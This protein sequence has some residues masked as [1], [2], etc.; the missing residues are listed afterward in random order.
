M[1]RCPHCGRDSG[2]RES[3]NTKDSVTNTLA[4]AAKVSVT[5]EGGGWALVL[6]FVAGLAVVLA[7]FM[8]SE[9]LK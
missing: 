9:L 8:V 7:S 4:P 6:L 1:S 3:Q 2:Y 5:Q